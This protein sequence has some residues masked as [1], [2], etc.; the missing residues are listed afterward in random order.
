[1]ALP[2]QAVAHVPAT[3]FLGGDPSLLAGQAAW[4][5]VLAIAARLGWI[6]ARRRLVVVG[7]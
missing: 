1:M 7:G 6:G 4:A 5:A 3:L 2:F